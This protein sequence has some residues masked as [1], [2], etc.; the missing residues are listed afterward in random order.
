M[1]VR[2]GSQGRLAELRNRWG[3]DEE[4]VVGD[5][6]RPLPAPPR[7][8]RGRHRAAQ[9][10][11]RPPLPPRRH[12]RHE[13]RRREPAGR[14]R[15]G[16]PSHG[17]ARRGG[18]GRAGPHGQLDRR[19]RALPGHL[20]RGHV[21]RGAEPRRQPLL[22]D[23][24]RVRAGRPRGV[25]AAVARLPAGDR[26]RQLGDRRDGQDRRAVLLLQADPA[27]PPGRPAVDADAR[28]RGPRDQ[29]RP[30]RL[31]RQGDGPHRPPRRPRRP[32]VPPHRP[33]PLTA[34]EVIDVFAR[35]AHAPQSD[36]ARTGSA[37]EAL[38]PA[39]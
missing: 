23:Q 29:H 6:R 8:L 17:P 7:R 28:R 16:D 31:R 10:Q 37:T 5:R 14:Q 33:D 12:L 9:G 21:R 26:R 34:G 36:R 24:A 4:R 22:P 27:D 25:H 3:V 32:G 15:R 11:G 19:R 1:L 35:A 2:E 38:Q 20:A 39:A 18:R 30:G 13:G